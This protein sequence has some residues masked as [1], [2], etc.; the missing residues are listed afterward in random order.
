MAR[1]KRNGKGKDSTIYTTIFDLVRAVNQLTNDDSLVVAAVSDLVNTYRTTMGHLSVP[2]KVVP[3]F[4][5]SGNGRG[6]RRIGDSGPPSC[7]W[8]TV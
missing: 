1:S 7:H 3:A 5:P 6:C 4:D 2:V 8:S